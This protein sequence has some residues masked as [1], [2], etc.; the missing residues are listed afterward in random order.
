VL[1]PRPDGSL[2]TDQFAGYSV[3]TR[4][5]DAADLTVTIR[6][7]N[8]DFV[9]AIPLKPVPVRDQ[10]GEVRDRITIKIANLCAHNALEWR[11]YR[12][13][14][15]VDKDVDFKWLYRL[16]EPTD[17]NY[18]TRLAGAELPVPVEIA[19]QAF[20][21]EDCMGGSFTTPIP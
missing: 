19:V 20:G 4:Q 16:L 7:F 11:E 13:R 2:Y 9:A 1:K 15:V 17:G 6:K 14:T 10:K 8:G 18:Q 12:R 21:D 5:V 3:W